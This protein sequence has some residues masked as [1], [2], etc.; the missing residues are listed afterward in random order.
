MQLVSIQVGRPAQLVTKHPVDGR[1]P[2]WQSGFYKAPVTGPVRVGRTNLEGDGQ[3]DLVNHGG[4]D[5]AVL[6]Y[7]AGRY[8][9][10]ESELNRSLPYG[11][12]G[13]NLTVTDVAEESVCIGDIYAIGEV[14]L[15]VAQPRFP[16][17]KISRR[18]GIPDLL[19]RVTQTG[20]TGWYLRV[21]QEGLIAPGQA[22]ALL[23]RPHPEWSVARAT[24]TLYNKRADPEAAVTLAACPALAERMRDNLL[25]K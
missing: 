12:F 23:E 4:P 10:W 21:L 22:I 3:A 7:A 25:R 16:C 6:A 20:R 17:W 14:R 19:E 18:W 2:E 15:Q 9:L 1:P 24:A 8:P 13:E 11:A 5:K